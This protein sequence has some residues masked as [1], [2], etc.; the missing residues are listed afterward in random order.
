MLFH[1]YVCLFFQSLEL[2]LVNLFDSPDLAVSFGLCPEYFREIAS[3]NE[4]HL[5]E[6]F[7]SCFAGRRLQLLTDTGKSLT[8]LCSLL[9]QTHLLVFRIVLALTLNIA[10][11]SLLAATASGHVRTFISAV[12]TFMELVIRLIERLFTH[13]FRVL[14]SF[15]LN[16]RSTITN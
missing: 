3:T 13:Y 12:P 1:Q 2:A 11:V 8:A 6:F 10:V 14:C 9:G 15:H 4:L 16:Y 5:F 7:D